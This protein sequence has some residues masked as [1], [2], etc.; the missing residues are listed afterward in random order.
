MKKPIKEL[1]G[2]TVALVAMGNSQ[3]DYHLSLTH[4]KTYDETWAI[5]AMCAATKADRVFAMDPMS[6]FFDTDDAGTQTEVM[7]KTLPTLK[8]PVYSVEKDERVPAIE[9][10]PI[11]EVANDTACTYFNNTVAYAIAFGLW[12]KIGALHIFGVDFSYQN[13]VHFGEMG[14]ACCEFWLAACLSEGMDVHIA[15]RSSLLDSNVNLKDKL[16]GYH[17]LEDPLVLHGEPG[18]LKLKSYADINQ[19]VQIPVGISDR[20]STDELLRPPEP[21]KA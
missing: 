14:R 8:C 15:T 9:L 17:R 3:L 7:R 11:E 18:K 20:W 5:N 12:N 1:A 10:Y 6:R 2:K 16:Y 19:P 4:S 13:N 21:K